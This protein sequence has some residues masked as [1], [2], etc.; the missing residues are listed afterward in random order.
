MRTVQFVNVNNIYISLESPVSKNSYNFYL[1]V[2][3]DSALLT[4]GFLTKY[5]WFAY[6]V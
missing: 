3:G 2:S 5:S 1:T 4:K 6:K